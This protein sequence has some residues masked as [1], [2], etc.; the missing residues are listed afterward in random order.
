MAKKSFSIPFKILIAIVLVAIAYGI[1]VSFQPL[2]SSFIIDVKSPKIVN[3]I[4]KENGVS[5]FLCD[6]IV[7]SY[8]EGNLSFIDMKT[9]DVSSAQIAVSDPKFYP[10]DEGV[11]VSDKNSNALHFLD[12]KAQIIWTKKFDFNIFDVKSIQK[13]ILVHLIKDKHDK[14]EIFSPK[15]KLQHSMFFIDETITDISFNQYVNNLLIYTIYTEQG[16]IDNKIFVYDNNFELKNLVNIHQPSFKTILLN[17]DKIITIGKRN[18]MCYNKNNQILWQKEYY[19]RNIDKL[20]NYGNSIAL[21]TSPLRKSNI[22]DSSDYIIFLNEDGKQ[23]GE[24][25][26]PNQIVDISFAKDLILIWE[27]RKFCILDPF[28]LNMREFD[29]NEDILSMNAT[30]NMVILETSD[31][32][33]AFKI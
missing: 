1:F 22:I 32:I 2:I 23:T 20:Y 3:K 13:N 6:D 15:G 33:Y 21:I 4:Q 8:D 28:D 7:L 12:K 26:L 30:K 29:I 14:I 16:K 11:F 19:S 9:L 27:K 10:I 31:Y 18:I 17:E 5:Y 25:K 24:F